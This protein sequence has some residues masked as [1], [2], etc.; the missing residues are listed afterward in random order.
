MARTT[1]MNPWVSQGWRRIRTGFIGCYFHAGLRVY[2]V[3]DPYY[4][5]E[6]AYFIPPNP[7]RPLF[8]VP[9]PGPLLGTTE[10]C[11][12]DDRGYIYVDTFHDGVY[13]LRMKLD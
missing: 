2:D 3:S 13:I 8:D 10:D 4:I 7:E 1:F 12:V 9:Q 6:L 5:K 11:V